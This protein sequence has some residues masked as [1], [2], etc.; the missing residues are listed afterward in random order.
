MILN[1]NTHSWFISIGRVQY[2][3]QKMLMHLIWHI[4]ICFIENMDFLVVSVSS[5]IILI[6]YTRY[7]HLL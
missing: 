3:F 5:S 7:V 1:M 4:P 6:V 2:T